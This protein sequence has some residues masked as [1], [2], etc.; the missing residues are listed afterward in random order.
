[1][2]YTFAAQGVLSPA[3]RQSVSVTLLTKC[4]RNDFKQKGGSPL[5]ELA[6]SSIALSL[7]SLLE[8]TATG[9]GLSIRVTGQAGKPFPC[10][11]ICWVILS[12]SSQY[13]TSLPSKSDKSLHAFCE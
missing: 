3:L 1:M 8:V 7:K 13:V 6:V 12:L 10:R 9:F 11:P 4:G 5:G 2:P